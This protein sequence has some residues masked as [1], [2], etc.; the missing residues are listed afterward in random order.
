M[1]KCTFLRKPI[2]S[3]KAATSY[4]INVKTLNIETNISEKLKDSCT[5][6]GTD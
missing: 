1:H 4:N 2:I 3:K 6:T 5:R